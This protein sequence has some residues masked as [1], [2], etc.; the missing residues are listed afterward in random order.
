MKITIGGQDYTSALDA[1]HPLTIE[2]KLNEPSVCQLW[3]ALPTNDSATLMRNQPIQVTG[4][5]GTN[6]FT[7]YL[8]ASP[9]PEYAGLGLEG[10]RYRF[11]LEA[12][13]DEYL[14]DQLPMASGKGA[15]GL[16]AGPLLSSLVAKTGSIAISTQALSLT[17]PVSTFT[18]APGASFSTGAGAASNEA[19]AAYRAANG[20]ITLATIPA[21][22]HVLDET[23]GNLA[24]GN[25]ALSAGVKRA[26]ANDITVCGEHEPTAYVTEYFLGDGVTTQFNL[27]SDAFALPPSRSTIIRELFNEGQID[28]RL[29]GNPGSHNY[30]SLGASGL[31]MQGGTGR[32]GD[33]QLAWID[34]VEMGGTLLLE[35]IGVTLANGSTGM[36]AGLFNGEQTQPGCTAGFQ[37]T[38]QQGTGAVAVQPFVMGLPTGS[39]YPIN[40]ANQ[41]TL[42]LRVH[43]P[44]CERG[45]AVYRSYSDGGTV[46]YGGQW[47]I[48]PANLLFEIQEFVSGVAGMPVILYN[49]QVVSLPGAGTVVAASCINLVGT[50]RALNLSNL[51]S[52]WVVTTPAGGAP[53][54][55]RTGTTAQAAE[56]HVES[57]GRLIFYT[58]FAP[59]AG[60]QIAVSY[61]AMG[62]SVGRSVNTASQQALAQA[63][64]PSVSAWLGSVTSP[65]PRSSQDCRNAALVMQMGATSVSA[66]WSGTYKCTRASLDADVWPGDALQLNAPSANLNAQVVV[67]NVTLSYAATY[68]DLVQYAIAFANDWADDLAIKTSASVPG[69]TWLPA[70]ISPTYLPNLNALAVATM[71]GANVIINAGATAPS[72]GGFEIRRRDNCFMPGA[73]PDVVMRGSQSTMTF[74]RTSASDRFYIRMYNGSTPPN[75]SEFSAALIFNLPLGI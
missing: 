14:L 44:E 50:M 57:T 30:L 63:G 22:I 35:A 52:G 29:W 2:R 8:A 15:A 36:L 72:G 69:D 38:A 43:C 45:L 21:A 34:P 32:D 73:D 9:M 68:P 12:I 54:T 42:R 17:T 51:G 19:C 56:C 37:V 61:R 59:P 27:S 62:R 75:Y 49:G 53:S 58:G 66:L 55:R 24:L 18:P 16:N 7:G 20:A 11:A 13:S 25:L 64:L 5:D 47:N 40:P 23:Q 41:Y 60:E 3:V 71:T 6:Y 26:L 4:D 46:S 67:R 74:A 28:L 10:P 33:T 65:A 1:T 48:A 39:L 31:S 70:A